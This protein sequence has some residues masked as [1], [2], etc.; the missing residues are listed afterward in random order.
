VLPGYRDGWFHAR[1]RDLSSLVGYL[2]SRAGKPVIDQTGLTGVWDVDLKW[3]PRPALSDAPA[4][5]A[6]IDFG[7]IVTAMREQ[8]GLKLTPTNAEVE[9]L[10]IERVLR[11]SPN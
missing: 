11:P 7:S 3:D 6:D 10:V 1:R 5:G 4:G 8:L 2:G 9:A